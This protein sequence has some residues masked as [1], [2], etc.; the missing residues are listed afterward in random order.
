MRRKVD[1]R[2]IQCES[3]VLGACLPSERFSHGGFS[4]SGSQRTL[5]YTYQKPHRFPVANLAAKSLP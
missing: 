1:R 5:K 2:G 4:I 3:L